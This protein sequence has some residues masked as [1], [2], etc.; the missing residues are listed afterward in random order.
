MLPSLPPPTSCPTHSWDRINL[1]PHAPSASSPSVLYDSLS[2][3][4][5]WLILGRHLGS[6]WDVPHGRRQRAEYIRILFI[7]K[8]GE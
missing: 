6:V 4:S 1:A 5:A 7:L 2:L 8:E 3:S